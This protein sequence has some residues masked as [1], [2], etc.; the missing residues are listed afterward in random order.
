MRSRIASID[1]VGDRKEVRIST[2]RSAGRRAD[3]GTTDGAHG[4]GPRRSAT[5]SDREGGELVSEAVGFFQR[6]ETL[7][8]SIASS[9]FPGA[10]AF[11]PRGAGRGRNPP[12]RV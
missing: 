6:P 8:T 5:R 3:D 12:G 4:R 2:G 1:V 11:S 7:T 9:R 10:W